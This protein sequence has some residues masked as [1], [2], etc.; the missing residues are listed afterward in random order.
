MVNI[1]ERPDFSTKIPNI[2]LSFTDESPIASKMFKEWQEFLKDTPAP[3]LPEFR[4][5]LKARIFGNLKA[6]RQKVYKT[7][8]ESY[9]DGRNYVKDQL[10]LATESEVDHTRDRLFSES[11]YYLGLVRP[12]FDAGM[13]D[14]LHNVASEWKNPRRISD[15]AAKRLDV[16]PQVLEMLTLDQLLDFVASKGYYLG[17]DP[18]ATVNSMGDSENILPTTSVKFSYAGAVTKTTWEKVEMPNPN[19]QEIESPLFNAI[20]ETIKTWD[21][22]VPGAYGGYCAATGSHVKAIMDGMISNL[23]QQKEEV[24]TTL[25]NLDK[26]RK[27]MP[28]DPATDDGRD[29]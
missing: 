18:F 26:I 10:E 22:N 2:D 25:Y 5:P 14:E 29:N 6:W 19:R 12:P 9:F 13:F 11:S 21:I 3:E 8:K 28:H 23:E 4:M 16:K 20:Y 24:E 1:N 27:D 15:A 17:P 7:D